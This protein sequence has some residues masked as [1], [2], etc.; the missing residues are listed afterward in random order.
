MIA[1]ISEPIIYIGRCQEAQADLG[2]RPKPCRKSLYCSRVQESAY[3]D[4]DC[5]D[6]E[7]NQ[8]S[9]VDN[10]RILC[11]KLPPWSS[12]HGAV[13]AFQG[14]WIS[15]HHLLPQQ[16]GRRQQP[17]TYPY[18]MCGLRSAAK[19]WS[20]INVTRVKISEIVFTTASRTRTVRAPTGRTRTSN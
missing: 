7:S 11:Q 8:S 12:S 3:N 1:S 18:E 14:G 9:R 4:L 17:P 10:P 16:P 19:H 5:F 20:V 15:V 13:R 2:G 6:G